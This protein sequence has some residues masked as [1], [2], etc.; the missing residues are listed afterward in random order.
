M[1]M[2][3][4]VVLAARA[5]N[6]PRPFPVPGRF[7]D[8][9]SLD[10][11]YLKERRHSAASMKGRFFRRQSVV[12]AAPLVKRGK[13]EAPLAIVPPLSRCLW[14]QHMKNECLRVST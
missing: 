3:S 12:T 11:Q 6:R 4:Q 2:R 13:L 5:K 1:C 9:Y 10:F 14:S 8:M 7:S